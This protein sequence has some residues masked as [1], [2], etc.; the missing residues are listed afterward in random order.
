MFALLT[1]LF[2]NIGQLEVIQ[3][4]C[5]NLAH[6]IWSMRQQVKQLQQLREGLGHQQGS[7]NDQD[8]M[9]NITECLTNLVTGTFIIE[10]QPP[11]VRIWI[12]LCVSQIIPIC[13]SRQ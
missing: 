1:F 12:I 6:I 11:Q 3:E 9:V 4:W 10:K 7:P 2:F 13:R 5:E 8:L